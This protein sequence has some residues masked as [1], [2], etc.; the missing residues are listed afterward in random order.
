[1]ADSVQFIL[2]LV[3][4]VL[5]L[6]LVILGWQVF[7]ILKDFRKTIEKTNKVLD[8]ATSITESVATPISALSSLSTTL[9]AGSLISII[10]IV[11]GF[12]AKD[13]EVEKKH[14]E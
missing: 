11:R 13:D 7:L 10:K 3:V 6:L 4:I 2:F 1:M 8:G 5:T 9:K 12:L 14:K